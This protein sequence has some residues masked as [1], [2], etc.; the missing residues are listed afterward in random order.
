M[1]VN[2]FLI[3]HNSISKYNNPLSSPLFIFAR[4]LIIRY[5]FVGPYCGFSIR[6]FNFSS[7]GNRAMIVMRSMQ[8]QLNEAGKSWILYSL[9]VVNM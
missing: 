8:S 6:N 1:I 9:N 5:S 2:F 3:T 7:T 4:D